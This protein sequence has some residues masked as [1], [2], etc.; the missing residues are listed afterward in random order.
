MHNRYKSDEAIASE[1]DGFSIAK[2]EHGDIP[3]GREY[4]AGHIYIVFP[5]GGEHVGGGTTEVCDAYIDYNGDGSRI[6]FDNWYPEV[7]Y[8]E[9][10]K[11]V[12]ESYAQ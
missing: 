2:I 11:T 7:V 4:R 9:L 10:C 6:A 3:A 12:R 5:N 8:E 1:F